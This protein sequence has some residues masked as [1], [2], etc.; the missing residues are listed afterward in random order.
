[1]F[2]IEEKINCKTITPCTITF[3]SAKY[4]STVPEIGCEIRVDI[5]HSQ[6]K[7]EIC[8]ENSVNGS[9]GFANF[10]LIIALHCTKFPITLTST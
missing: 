1:M 5:L 4:L 7:P 3:H 6:K 2:D 10:F 9:S 8:H